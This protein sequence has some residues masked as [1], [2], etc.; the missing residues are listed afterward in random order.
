MPTPLA[1]RSRLFVR[2]TVACVLLTACGRSREDPHP[3]AALGEAAN[4][5][6]F[7]AAAAVPPAVASGT[8]TVGPVS[9]NGP[10]PANAGSV[11]QGLRAGFRSCY[12]AALLGAPAV[13]GD[14]VLSAVVGP[15]GEVTSAQTLKSAGVPEPLSDCLLRKLRNV[16][17][18]SPGPAGVTVTVPVTLAPAR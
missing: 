2:A 17:F 13:A 10:V 8:V 6:A 1:P 16:Q 9:S 5:E 11:T 7:I 15:T 14:V 4:I 12:N 18:D 3:G